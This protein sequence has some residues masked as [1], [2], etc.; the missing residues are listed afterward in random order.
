MSDA[1]ASAGLV[2]PLFTRKDSVV[3]PS[4]PLETAVQKLGK[5][6]AEAMEELVALTRGQAYRLVFAIV[7]DRDR[8]QDV[9]QDAYLTVYQKISQLREVGAFQGWFTRI[10]VNRARRELRQRLEFLDEHPDLGLLAQPQPELEDR[11]LL[12]AALARLG[13]ADRALLS[14]REIAGLS[15][16]EI[17][18]ALEIPPGTVGSRL[19]SA[20]QRLLQQ[21][22]LGGSPS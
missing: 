6:Q 9:L 7:Q 16:T 4:T 15:Y 21:V 3:T 22:S 1:V 11:L 20:R 8:S 2:S 17:A 18:Q 5:G 19:F 13:P 14:L 12:Q 10:L